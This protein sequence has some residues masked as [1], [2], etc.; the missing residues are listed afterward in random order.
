[1]RGGLTI[2]EDLAEG[3]LRRDVEQVEQGLAAVI[4]ATL[5]QGQ[6]DALSSL[7]FNLRGGAYRLPSI[8]PRLVAKLNEGDYAGAADELLDI[9]RANGLVL[10]GL[11]R[12]RVAERALFV[13]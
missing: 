12:R 6:Y 2:T 8:A 4:H 10:P 3:F 7:C 13:A 9:D 1:V 11:V 5:T